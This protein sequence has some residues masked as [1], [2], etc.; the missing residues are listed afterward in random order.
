MQRIALLL[1][2]L[3]CSFASWAEPLRYES[4]GFAFYVDPIPD[5]VTG[6]AVPPLPGGD[7]TASGPVRM[8]LY[9]RQVLITAQGTTKFRRVIWRV[10]NQAGIESMSNVDT[11]FLPDYQKLI[12]HELFVTRNGKRESRLDPGSVRLVANENELEK[13]VYRGAVVASIFVKD[14]RVG[15]EV[16]LS[17]SIEGDNPVFENRLSMLFPLA[18]SGPMD[19]MRLMLRSTTG[20]PYQTRVLNSTAQLVERS[21]AGF[22]ETSVS[23]DNVPAFSPEEDSPLS[24]LYPMVQFGEYQTWEEVASWAGR[25]F[26]VPQ[27]LPSRLRARVDEWRKQA[28]S[29]QEA[30][31]LATE[32]VQ[33]EIAYVSV[34]I[35]ENSHRPAP[36][37]VVF[38]RGFG[39][40]KDKALLLS[41]LLG[42][43][44]MDA[45]P[46]L[47]SWEFG[48]TI[49]EML[50]GTYAFDHA[51]TVLSLDGNTYWLDGTA[52]YQAG[53][54]SERFAGDY[55][56]ALALGA[57]PSSLVAVS[58]PTGYRTSYESKHR[59]R[60]SSFAQPVELTIEGTYGGPSADSMRGYIQSQGREK[61]EKWFDGEIR[62]IFPKMERQKD[63][64]LQDEESDNRLSF[65][66]EIVLPEFFSRERG[67]LNAIVVPI[68]LLDRLRSVEPKGRKSPLRLRHPE[69]VDQTI[70][71][72]F[73]EDVAI[74]SPD[75]MV[76]QNDYR[77]FSMEQRYW[78]RRLTATYHYATRRDEIPQSQLQA[79]GE[80]TRRIRRLSIV[81]LAIPVAAT[82][83]LTDL[84]SDVRKQASSIA[85]MIEEDNLRELGK[86]TA[87]IESGRLTRKQLVRAYVEHAWSLER[88][89]RFEEA[90]VDV[91]RALELDPDDGEAHETLAS[92][93]TS[94]RRF[95]EAMEAYQ[96]AE[97]KLPDNAGLLFGRGRL[98]YYWGKYAQAERDFR[99]A[100]GGSA[101]REQPYYLAWLF[102]S[103]VRGGGNG[104][105]AIEGYSGGIGLSEWPGPV[106]TMFLG[107]LG[108]D[109]VLAIA[110]RADE[111]TS[112]LQQCEA[113]FFIGQHYLMKGALDKASMAFQQAKATGIRQYVEYQFSS[114]ELDALAG[115]RP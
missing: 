29:Q 45:H 32:Y 8:R 48:N 72:E 75:P 25:L 28:G 107:D 13:R 96:I 53:P 43:L 68:A 78:E 2:A 109:E 30:A 57:S 92:E 59:Y 39:D 95:E 20:K 61:F 86:L 84:K 114:W 77:T 98:Y 83:G 36:P 105:H 79:D 80:F 103:V 58:P 110:K 69:S 38:E 74:V 90:I 112:L 91:R 82:S 40:C 63:I 33:R 73:P 76:L 41:A 46:A 64:E 102:M 3:F 42:E 31:R 16:D 56:Y 93:L 97:Q 100:L 37:G 11:G 104:R 44:G 24:S 66:S 17:L 35:G 19:A 99:R 89:E 115:K 9:D 85:S 65:K 7:D 1:T 14:L 26:D 15:D 60:V 71:V 52:Q 101:N 62:R 22:T 6:H 88:L 67:K 34:S 106:V 23:L 4:G 27:T 70:I 49:S 50:P 21:G 113:Q 12:F 54:L 51:L 18:T 5:W 47:V 94:L 55:G 87:E 111:R 10:R 81:S 108:P